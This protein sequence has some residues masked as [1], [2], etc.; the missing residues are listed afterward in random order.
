MTDHALVEECKGADCKSPFVLMYKAGEEEQP[1]YEGE[2]KADLLKA[3]AAAKS[4]PLVIKF[5]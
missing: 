4:L 5:G 1:R 3:W 2:F